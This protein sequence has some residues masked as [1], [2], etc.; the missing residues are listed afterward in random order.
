MQKAF[1]ED[2]KGV[3]GFESIPEGDPRNL[4][5]YI[6]KKTDI[7]KSINQVGSR[8][9]ELGWTPSNAGNISIRETPNH[10]RFYITVS[11]SQFSNLQPEDL[12]FIHYIEIVIGDIPLHIGANYGIDGELIPTRIIEALRKQDLLEQVKNDLS[13]SDFDYVHPRSCKS[14]NDILKNGYELAR[15]LNFER[16]KQYT[17]DLLEYIRKE[18][19]ESGEREQIHKGV[20]DD[21]IALVDEDKKRMEKD[22]EDYCGFPYT[23]DMI[24]NDMYLLMIAK[25]HKLTDEQVQSLQEFKEKL[26]LEQKCKQFTTKIE[27][28][29]EVIRYPISTESILTERYIKSLA[30]KHS[31]TEE[32]VESLHLARAYENVSVYEVYQEDFAEQDRRIINAGLDLKTLIEYLGKNDLINCKVYYT[33][34]REPSSETVLHGLLYAKRWEY[35]DI[36]A[37]VHCHAP[38]ITKKTPKGIPVTETDQ[39]IIGYGSLEL[40]VE[41]M[42]SLG[43]K[44]CVL[45][46]GHGPVAVSDAWQCWIPTGKKGIFGLN[47]H[48]LDTSFA[49]VFEDAFKVLKKADKSVTRGLFNRMMGLINR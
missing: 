17:M 48:V 41:A 6:T 27:E 44:M 12:T 4:I 5:E 13:A 10:T 33:G 7:Y 23:P 32:Q 29:G 16:C 47:E 22:T 38:K 21:L 35:D 30:K 9:N 15:K 19:K 18:I 28:T 46:R 14:K 34:S 42:E 43:E 20:L 40:A 8:I 1:I 36:N 31:L 25:G 2:Y 45:L 3:V 49:P 26:N 11:G 39:K 37:I 24:I